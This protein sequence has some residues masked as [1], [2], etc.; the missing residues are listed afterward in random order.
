MHQDLQKSANYTKNLTLL[1]ITL[2]LFGLGC[3]ILGYLFLPFAAA[4]YASLLHYEKKTRRVFS[5]V[6]PVAVYTINVLIN[7]FFSLEGIIYVAVGALLYFFTLKDRSKR[8]AVFYLTLT[9]SVFII[10]SVFAVGFT[11]NDSLSFSALK[12]YYA[13]LYD[14]FKRGFISLMS[15]V[16]TEDE[17]GNI[18]FLYT[19][20]NAEDVFH[21]L[22]L[23]LP[24]FVIILAFFLTGV[25]Y[26]IFDML[27]VR[28]FEIPRGTLQF[29]VPTKFLSYS[30][31][32]VAILSLFSTKAADIFSLSILNVYNVLLVIF[33]YFG[34]K[35]AYAIVKTARGTTF[36]TLLVIIALTMFTSFAIS[37]LSFIG[38]FFAINSQKVNEN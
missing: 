13:G 31:V 17:L 18:F 23:S 1:C 6:L 16:L 20:E 2:G 5:Y 22:L 37:L 15:S 26:K 34:L 4:T 10:L 7:G 35:I 3:T 33:A 27:R 19:R 29:F 38:V 11:M 25:T 9:I 28:I 12:A 24:S 32:V 30:Y 14:A 21:S 8:E 36:A